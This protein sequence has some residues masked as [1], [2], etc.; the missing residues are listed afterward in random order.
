VLALGV[1]PLLKRNLLAEASR[2]IFIHLLGFEHRPEIKDKLKEIIFGTKLLR[3]TA[4]LRCLVE[5]GADGSFDFT[6]EY[7]S[8]LV[9]PTNTPIEYEPSMEFDKAHKLE[10]LEM[11]FTSSDGKYKWHDKPEPKEIYPGVEVAR[12]K[13]FTI[14]P[15]SR[16][17]TYRGHSK[18]KILVRYGYCQFTAGRPTLQTTMQATVPEGYEVGAT[19]ATVEN[20]NYW[21]YDSI[22]MK[23]EH[24][25]LRWRKKNGE[26]L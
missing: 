24:I 18:Y 15:E 13:K 19:P 21:Q 4:D 14:Q 2:G 20:V 6:V 1:D 22:F 12:G 17:I 8:E 5:E 23:G 16:G 26:W 9:N 25:T 11:T 10:V 3:K 7:D